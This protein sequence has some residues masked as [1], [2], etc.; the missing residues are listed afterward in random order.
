MKVL[1]T[2]ATGFLGRHVLSSL[3]DLGYE[4]RALTR[5]KPTWSATANV[6]WIEGD[7]TVDD[8]R[9]VVAGCD[10]VIHLAAQLTGPESEQKRIATD[11]TQRLL[12]AMDGAG[13]KR[14]VLASS[15]SVYDWNLVRKSVHEGSR[16]LDEHTGTDAGGYAIAK[17][18]QERLALDWARETNAQLTILRPAALWDKE[19]IPSFAVGQAVGPLLLVIAPRR[20]LHLM[21]VKNC[22]D[23]FA[24][25]L[26]QPEAIDRTINLCDSER[27]TAWQLAWMVSKPGRQVRI[28][29]PY[30]MGRVASSVL[31]WIHGRLLGGRIRIPSLLIPRQYVARF[32]PTACSNDMMKRV[33]GWYSPSFFEHA[34][35]HRVQQ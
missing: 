5:C 26:S 35:K 1:V 13:V 20:R 3:L 22:A 23:A 7:L 16:L 24:K 15:F 29:I 31:Y 2:G 8:L 28:P 6:E 9:P 19:H 10:A 18:A 4:V 33:F 34:R 11:G 17:L 30:F 32:R 21:H 27:I 14:F 25:A 12:Q